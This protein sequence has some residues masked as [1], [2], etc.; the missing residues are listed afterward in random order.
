MVN[1][2]NM[3]V[4]ERTVIKAQKKARKVSAVLQYEAPSSRVNRMPP[5]GALKAAAM[6]V[7]VEFALM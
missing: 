6:P 5:I 2:L 3:M 4:K 1:P 7:W